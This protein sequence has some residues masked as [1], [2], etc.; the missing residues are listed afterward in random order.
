MDPRARKG[1]GGCCHGSMAAGTART[2]GMA[3][4]EDSTRKG[5]YLDHRSRRQKLEAM[6]NQTTSPQEAAIARSKLVEMRKNDGGDHATAQKSR[7]LS[8]PGYAFH[9]LCP[10]CGH[11]AFLHST[12]SGYLGCT[13]PKCFCLYTF[14]PYPAFGLDQGWH[15]LR[16]RIDAKLEMDGIKITEMYD[17]AFFDAL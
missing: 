4:T 15:S 9:G 17:N 2:R 1:T 6:A 3:G 13:T 7:P 16:E 8:G 5:T 10:G 14:F 12:P 11:T